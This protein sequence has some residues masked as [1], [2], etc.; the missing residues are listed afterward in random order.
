[1]RTLPCKENFLVFQK[2]L[3]FYFRFSTKKQ[4]NRH[5]I[6]PP[7]KTSHFFDKEMFVVGRDY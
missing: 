7:K 3:I 5:P 2:D 4:T 6:H 1:M